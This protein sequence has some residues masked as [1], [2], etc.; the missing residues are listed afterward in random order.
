MTVVPILLYVVVL[1][2]ALVYGYYYV[3]LMRMIDEHIKKEARYV[4]NICRK[5]N[6]DT[7]YFKLRLNGHAFNHCIKKVK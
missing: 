4:K 6:I 2:I 1:P 7:S 5:F 3:Q